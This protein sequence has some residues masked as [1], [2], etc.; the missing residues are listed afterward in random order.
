MAHAHSRR[1]PNASGADTALLI[2]GDFGQPVSLAVPEGE[3][4]VWVAFEF[5]K[6]Y[7]A[8]AI[9]IAA[10]PVQTFIG[11]AIPMARW[12]SGKN[13]RAGR[14]LCSFLDPGSP[15]GNFAL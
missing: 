5:L 13:G 2:D 4:Q 15:R 14:P 7:R 11:S 6:P 9:T 12:N 8:Q 3:R 1:T 10:A